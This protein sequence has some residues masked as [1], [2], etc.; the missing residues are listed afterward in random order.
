MLC[1]QAMKGA[2]GRQLRR[3]GIDIV[4]C[5][6]DAMQGLPNFV[7]T[8]DKIRY[9]NKLLEVGYHTVDFGSFVSAPAVPQ[10]RDTVDV[11]KG[12]NLKDTES[13]LLAVVCNVRGA[14]DAAEF[15]QIKY[16]GF[17]LSMSEEFQQRNTRRGIESALEMLAKM[18][19]ICANSDKELVT[20]ISMAFGN[21]YGEAY[22]PEL[23]SEFVEKVAKMGCK[24][25]SLADTVGAGDADLITRVF[26]D[27]LPKHPEVVIGAHLHSSSVSA[28][29]KIQ[30]LM[31][32]GCPRIDSA[33]GGMGGCPFAKSA[34]IGNV[35]TES[36]I[37][38]AEKNGIDLGLNMKAFE[39]AQEIKHELFGVA[40][41]E[42]ILQCYMGDDVAFEALCKKHFESADT[43]GNGTLSRDEFARSVRKVVRELGEE[44]P[45]DEK[46]DKLWGQRHDVKQHMRFAEY[47]TLAREK[48]L[49]RMARNAL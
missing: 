18:Q 49:G 43:S 20:Y 38:K 11:L 28:P 44:P 6:R 31:D 16:L 3:K 7:Q 24:T 36:V 22:S 42:I 34:L 14:Q 37:E 23:V 19:D 40:V 4:E 10:M 15:E 1:R 35:P 25:I 30:A 48:I 13:K 39:E 29:E 45:A 47:S 33:V 32:V 2:V 41:S 17:P 26:T 27:V 21:P 9:I 46:I 12:L 8:E 5:P